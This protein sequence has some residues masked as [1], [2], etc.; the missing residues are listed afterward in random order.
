MGLTVQ[1]T[2]VDGSIGRNKTDTPGAPPYDPD[3]QQAAAEMERLKTALIDVCNE[4]G[5]H[6]ASEAGTLVKRM[7]DAEADI[8]SAQS[9]IT[10]AQSDISNLQAVSRDANKILS[11]SIPAFP[12][13]GKKALLYDASGAVLVWGSTTLQD[14]YDAGKTI[15]TD[16]TN[17]VTIDGS[18][19]TP[20]PIPL[21]LKGIA[22][23][24]NANGL[25]DTF[26][27]AGQD[28]VGDT[29]DATGIGFTTG[30]GSVTKPAGSMSFDTGGNN[31]GGTGTIALGNNSPADTFV[32]LGKSN[33][34]GASTVIQGDLRLGGIISP[35]AYG[36]DQNDLTESGQVAHSSV[37]R[38]SSSVAN[39]NI[40]GIIAPASSHSQVLFIFN[41]GSNLI[42]LK[43]QNTGSGA[44]ARFAIAG[45]DVPIPAGRVA[46]L[47]YDF[48]TQRW[49]VFGIPVAITQTGT[50][51]AI[52]A[53]G[54]LG[55]A[56]GGLVLPA[57][58]VHAHGAQTDGT[59]HAA[60]IAAGAS[61]FMTG[62][63]KTKLDSITVADLILRGG[64]VPFTADQSMGSHKLTNVTDPG[65]AQD[66]ATKAYVDA[67]ASPLLFAWNETDTSQFQISKDEIASG[68][69][70]LSVQTPS[71]NGSPRLRVAFPTKVTGEKLCAIT[72]TGIDLQTLAD[73]GSG[74]YRYM[75]EY[76]LIGASI[77]LS[78]WYATGPLFLCADATGASFYAL[79]WGN[80]LGVASRGTHIIGGTVNLSGSTPTW[81]NS[82]FSTSANADGH[83]KYRVIVEAVKTNGAQPFFIVTLQMFGNSA[84]Q[85]AEPSMAQHDG[86]WN[87]I[88]A[89]STNWNSV[90]PK[91]VGFFVLGTTGTTTNQ[92]FEFADIRVSKHPSDF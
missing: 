45:V 17:P 79:G 5:L 81:R 66:A 12:V 68:S 32:Y 43:S 46:A 24:L 92:Y 74:R 25:N 39:V 48:T 11:K 91:T 10:A 88:A 26:F 57:D 37:L 82:M 76:T 63:D 14:A 49:R 18:A 50:P 78:E 16:S 58:H 83:D 64:T 8:T 44:T 56:T 27:I 67:H 35:A 9:D 34:S 55:T 40:T 22:L 77:T 80:N 69:T 20:F 65:S 36:I 86:T 61:G 21:A 73:K 70:T 60:V 1:P 75:F 53:T 51:A 85:N 4:V 71:R 87:T 54:S 30:D 59:M 3:H 6:D 31:G 38:L 2:K 52:A 41:V 28:T 72:I 62:T 89:F 84:T 47:V 7:L 42:T 15:T 13:S 23:V 90:L 19:V 29:Q 33:V